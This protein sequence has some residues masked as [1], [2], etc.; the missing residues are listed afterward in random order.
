LILG[1]DEVPALKL[2]HRPKDSARLGWSTW[3]NSDERTQ[4][5]EDT[6]LTRAGA[7]GGA[8]RILAA[9]TFMEATQ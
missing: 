4:D 9:D 3:L 6:I 8:A 5:S 2:E 7:P 1:R